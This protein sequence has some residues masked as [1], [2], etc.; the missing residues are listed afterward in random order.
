MQYINNLAKKRDKI[1]IATIS[2]IFLVFLGAPQGS[3][4]CP[5]CPLLSNLH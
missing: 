5:L 2:Y 4:L 1:S 3:V